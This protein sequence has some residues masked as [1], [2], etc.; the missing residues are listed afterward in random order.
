MAVWLLLALGHLGGALLDF[1]LFVEQQAESFSHLGVV[2]RH[3]GVAAASM[4]KHLA[5]AARALLAI[6]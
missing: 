6:T 3:G 1:A 2:S 4:A 5:V